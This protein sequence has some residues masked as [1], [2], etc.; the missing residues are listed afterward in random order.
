MVNRKMCNQYKNNNFY[1]IKDIVK[2]EKN[3]MSGK[4]T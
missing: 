3:Q 4:Y 2:L 1:M